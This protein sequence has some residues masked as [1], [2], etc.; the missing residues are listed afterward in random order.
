MH[1]PSPQDWLRVK[2]L[3]RYLKGTISDS[4]FHSNISTS[5]LKS[6]VMQ[7]GLAPLSI[8]VLNGPILS[9]LEKILYPGAPENKKP[10]RNPVLKPY[11]RQ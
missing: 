11:I 9:F 1:D 5:L 8:N 6:L 10:S 7:I 2:H 4:L 3:L